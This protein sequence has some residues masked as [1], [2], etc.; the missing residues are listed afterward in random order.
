MDHFVPIYVIHS[1]DSIVRAQLRAISLFASQGSFA[2]DPYTRTVVS[3]TELAPYM[4][5]GDIPRF[6]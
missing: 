6:E 2:N 5:M 1:V 4:R 3:L